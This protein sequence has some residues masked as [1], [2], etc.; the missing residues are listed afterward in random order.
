MSRREKADE[1]KR[2]FPTDDDSQRPLF[3]LEWAEEFPAIISGASEKRTGSFA[4]L[5][6]FRPLLEGILELF[7]IRNGCYNFFT[8]YKGKTL[9]TL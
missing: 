5:Y 2:V 3:L 6:S 7:L 4:V 9:D 1:E 8:N